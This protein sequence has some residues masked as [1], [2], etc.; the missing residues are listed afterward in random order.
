MYTGA[1]STCRAEFERHPCRL[2]PESVS[3]ITCCKL[4]YLISTP[5]STTRCPVNKLI[6]AAALMLC[7]PIHSQAPGTASSNAAASGILLSTNL[8]AVILRV[9]RAIG[10]GTGAAFGGGADADTST[11][12]YCAGGLCSAAISRPAFGCKLSPENGTALLA[13]LGVT[14]LMLGRF[15]YRRLNS[16]HQL[17][18]S[19][20]A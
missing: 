3:S 12:G 14:G 17:E 4:N 13:V 8:S 11:S 9:N 19:T 10:V 6:A 1:T 16:T 18:T 15:S 2:P 7:L 5:L 20:L